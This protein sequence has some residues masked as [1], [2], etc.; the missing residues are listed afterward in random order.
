[1]FDNFNGKLLIRKQ[2]AYEGILYAILFNC[3]FY[4]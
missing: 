3:F 2:L 1:M 4:T